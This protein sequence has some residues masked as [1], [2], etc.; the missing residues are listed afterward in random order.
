MSEK[1]QRYLTSEEATIIDH[2]VIRENMAG[3]NKARYFIVDSDWQK[4]LKHREEEVS[5][6]NKNQV[7]N[8][9]DTVPNDYED[10][11][12][13]LSAYCR[14]EKRILSVEEYCKKYNQ[15]YDSIS[16]HKF[17]PHHYREPAYNIVFKET[18]IEQEAKEWDWE[19]IISKHIKPA[20]VSKIRDHVYRPSLADILTYTDGH[21][22][23]DTDGDRNAMYAE[24]WDRDNIIKSCDLMIRTTK[25]KK[26]SNI[27]YVDELG[28]FMD[29]FNAQTTRGG[30]ALP[31]NMTNEEAYDCGLE[32]KIRLVDGLVNE[33][34]QVTFNNICNDNHAGAF[35]YT[36]NKAFKEICAV[37]YPDR[38]IV[39]NYRQFMSHYF[40]G[41]N[42]FI[43]SHG[44][45][46]K[47]LKF[48]FKPQLDSKGL[49]KIDQYCKQFDLY[50]QADL[51]VFKKGDSHQCLMDM[52][53]SDDFYYF[54]Y[55]ALSPSSTWVQN[56]F[57]KGRRGFV[58]E[59][60]K[61]GTITQS[62][63]FIK[64]L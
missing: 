6:N 29:G 41:S 49:E 11:P 58:N 60:L 61:E 1:K 3:R 22:G 4:V 14:E 18:F 50:R 27:L 31:Q 8:T 38:V 30:H 5:Y 64:K 24:P 52:A 19:A 9:T 16:S 46:D 7:E 42:C 23:M 2:K 43:I 13:F 15:P 56:N 62:V 48:G 36:V 37:K 53:T 17:L 47:S 20:V 55:P 39:N 54:N 51:I 25:Q 59:S 35:G 28:D 44:K 57:K 45:D 40:I 63:K 26:D 21:V 33:Y 32:F 34:D 10:E 12:F